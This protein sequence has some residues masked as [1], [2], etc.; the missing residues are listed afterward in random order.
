MN[1]FVTGR[2]AINMQILI[3]PSILQRPHCPARSPGNLSQLQMWR[4]S[5]SEATITL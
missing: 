5:V 1:L 3:L 2:E 4:T